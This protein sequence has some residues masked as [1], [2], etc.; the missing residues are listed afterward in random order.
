MSNLFKSVQESFVR[1]VFEFNGTII[2]GGELTLTESPAAIDWVREGDLVI[3]TLERRFILNLENGVN[4]PSSECSVLK[5]TQSLYIVRIKRRVPESSLSV[6]HSSS[7]FM[8]PTRYTIEI[9]DGKSSS[10][11]TCKV[12]NTKRIAYDIGVLVKNPSIYMKNGR[13]Y[14]DSDSA[15][16]VYDPSTSSV[17][18]HTKKVFSAGAPIHLLFCQYLV[19]RD[20]DRAKEMLGFDLGEQALREYFGNIEEALENNYLGEP[21]TV[22]LLQQN[23]SIKTFRFEIDGVKI[24]NVAEI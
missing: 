1:I 13:I 6:I 14:M 18:N 10:Y 19:N 3:D 16:L 21:E 23:G 11:F 5:I 15:S 22:T 20:F 4:I 2:L 8:F 9:A 17:E 12:G 24:S 7:H